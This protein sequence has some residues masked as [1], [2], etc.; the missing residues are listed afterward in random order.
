[1]FPDVFHNYK[2][3]KEL[4][5]CDKF[6]GEDPVKYLLKDIPKSQ[7]TYSRLKSRIYKK[8]TLAE[9]IKMEQKKKKYT[10]TKTHKEVPDDNNEFVFI[11]FIKANEKLAK[12][13]RKQ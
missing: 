7:F 8:Y 9:A 3:I 4:L 10:I 11:G 2:V 6:H 12:R 1:M 13:R 5:T